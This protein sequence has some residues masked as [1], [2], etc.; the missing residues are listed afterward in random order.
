[1]EPRFYRAG[2]QAQERLLPNKTA[3][4]K[5]AL[6]KLACK[7]IRAHPD[8]AGLDPFATLCS[9]TYCLRNSNPPSGQGYRKWVKAARKNS[10]FHPALSR[11]PRVEALS[12]VILRTFAVRR[13][14]RE[15]FLGPLSFRFLAR[16]SW[17][18]T[19]CCQ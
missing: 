11:L 5:Q 17:N 6:R 12:G 10:S 9:T 15:R 14:R 4:A 1:M 18:T 3:L 7:P 19:S 13:R 2:R 8:Q 16:S